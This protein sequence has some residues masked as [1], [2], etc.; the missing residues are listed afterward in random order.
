MPSPVITTPNGS[1]I[2]IQKI[3]RHHLV[4]LDH[5]DAPENMRNTEAGRILDG[6]FQPAPFPAFGLSPYVLRGIADLIETT[7]EN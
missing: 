6:G 4:I 3:G 2:T 7:R 5:P 1:T